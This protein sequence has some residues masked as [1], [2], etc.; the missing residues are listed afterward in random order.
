MFSQ[1]EL[2]ICMN[3]FFHIGTSSTTCCCVKR[4]RY[5]TVPTNTTYLCKHSLRKTFKALPQ[6]E[7]HAVQFLIIIIHTGQWRAFTLW[8]LCTRH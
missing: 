1:Y 5:S 8:N 3:F 7:Q 2:K 4:G 6:C